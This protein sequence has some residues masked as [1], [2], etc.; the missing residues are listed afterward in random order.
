MNLVNGF[1][2]VIKLFKFLDCENLKIC[3]SA[4]SKMYISCA[5]VHNGW[6]W[7]CG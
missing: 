1:L 4:V 6:A 7:L 3:L 2:A 5:L